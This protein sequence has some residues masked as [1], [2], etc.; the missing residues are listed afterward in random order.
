[1]CQ[2]SP[3]VCGR[4]AASNCGSVG[5]QRLH[6]K[7][8]RG[9]AFVSQAS[10]SL[11]WGE[12]SGLRP[13]CKL[14][15]MSLPLEKLSRAG[16]VHWCSSLRPTADTY[17]GEEANGSRSRGWKQPASFWSSLTG[18]QGWWLVKKKATLLDSPTCRSWRKNCNQTPDW[19]QKHQI[20]C[21]I[22][23]WDEK[24]AFRI[25]TQKDLDKIKFWDNFWVC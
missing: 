6:R 16:N 21:V 7:V 3:A 14:R 12:Y 19:F 2:N 24:I 20:N 9:E 11:P 10:A 25:W 13:H 17:G 23:P 22:L 1:M 8:K 18:Y 5:L 4:A 15:G